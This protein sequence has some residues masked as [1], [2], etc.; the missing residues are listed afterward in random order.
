MQGFSLYAAMR[1]DADDRKA[2]EP[3]CRYTIGRHAGRSGQVARS[4]ARHEQSTGLLVPRRCHA[5]ACLTWVVR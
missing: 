5:V 2:L 4:L 1:C 3:L